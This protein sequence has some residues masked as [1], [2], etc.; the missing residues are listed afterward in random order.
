DLPRYLDG[1]GARLDRLSGKLKRD[2]LGTQEIARWQ[3]RLSN[4]KSDQHEPHVKELFHLL[5][6]YRLSLFCQEKKT[7]VKMSPKRLEQEFAR[8]ESAE[9]K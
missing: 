9:Q 1:I 5:Q 8:W 2:L 3:N 4:L 6:E 7:R